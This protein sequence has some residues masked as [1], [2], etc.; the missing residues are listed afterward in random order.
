MA[1][2]EYAKSEE[3]ALC[4]PLITSYGDLLRYMRGGKENEWDGDM[5][6]FPLSRIVFA[7]SSNT[8]VRNGNDLVANVPYAQFRLEGF[9]PDQW[10]YVWDKDGDIAEG[11]RNTKWRSV[12]PQ[13]E[14]ETNEDD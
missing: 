1:A 13:K 8:D 10:I 2:L 4:V 6:T 3:M 9:G 5:I 11:L 14:E 7:L 12:F